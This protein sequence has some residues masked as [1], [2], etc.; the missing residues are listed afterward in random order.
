MCGLFY[1]ND[2]MLY[3]FVD[4][5]ARRTTDDS[6]MKEFSFCPAKGDAHNYA[7]ATETQMS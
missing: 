6:T 5:S 7:C 3:F 4:M 1:R 2:R